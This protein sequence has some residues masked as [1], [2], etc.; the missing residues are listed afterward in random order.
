[1][2][3][4]QSPGTRGS[5][6]WIQ[7]LVSSK[8]ALFEAKL[9]ATRILANHETITWLS[10]Q[11]EDDWAEYRDG[12]FLRLLGLERLSTD[13]KEFWPSR[14]PQWDALGLTSE[15][16]PVLVEAKAHLAELTSNCQASGASLAMIHAALQATKEAIG[17]QS[18][19][20]W[21]TKYY[22]YANRLAHLHF[23]RSRS[24]MDALLVF[25]YFTN[26]DEMRGPRTADEWKVGLQDAYAHLALPP[27]I[28]G[29]ADAFID[30][31][32]LA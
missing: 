19:S 22:Q 10:P 32:W 26:D 30:V 31:R 18:G 24:D 11:E 25:V 8:A 7:R 13:L 29:L 23:L 9:R 27:R 16:R 4:I 1:M 3:V 21:L 2:R 6:R 14:G 17:A 5:L 15:G 20:D 28:A 12:D